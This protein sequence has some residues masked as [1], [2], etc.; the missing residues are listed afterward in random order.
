MILDEVKELMIPEG[1][2]VRIICGT[3]V[4]WESAEAAEEV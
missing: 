2:V 1:R 4:L 3:E